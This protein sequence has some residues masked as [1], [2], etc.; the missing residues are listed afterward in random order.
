MI[1]KDDGTENSGGELANFHIWDRALANEDV[2]TM[3][4]CR[5]PDP[6]EPCKFTVGYLPPTSKT[7]YSSVRNDDVKG[8]GYARGRLGSKMAWVA[9]QAKIGEFMQIDSGMVQSIAGVITQGR[10]DRN[11]WVKTF[12]IQTSVD[13]SKWHDVA[14]G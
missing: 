3:C 9:K 1:M 8:K 10:R 6:G 11:E 5:K 14:C 7:F 12:S 13:G 2:Q 4:G